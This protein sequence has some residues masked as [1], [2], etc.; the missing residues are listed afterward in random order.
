MNLVIIPSVIKNAI[1]SPYLSET[2]RLEQ[3]RISIETVKDK[4]P[5]AYVV[6]IE[7][8]EL[9]TFIN[10]KLIGFGADEVCYTSVAGLG[11]SEGELTLLCSY[12]KSENFEKIKHKCNSLSKMSGRYFLTD[13]FDF[14]D[15]YIIN[16]IDKSWSGMGACSTRYW[17]VPKDYIGTA[18]NKI[19]FIKETIG[20]FIDIEHA[21]YYVDVVP[22]DNIIKEKSAGVS[23]IVSPFGKLENS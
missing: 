11:K 3:T 15:D 23:G 9:T 19:S 4:I 7:G 22:Q 13:E 14:T 20:N 6:I 18:I 2:E 21:F 1:L 10:S 8:G 16:C 5:N 17:K 12:L